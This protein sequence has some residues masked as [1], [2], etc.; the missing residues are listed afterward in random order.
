M[1]FILA[2]AP[3]KGLCERAST[4]VTSGSA[5]RPLEGPTLHG[6][7]ALGR[8]PTASRDNTS[9]ASSLS[10]SPSAHI[11][12]RPEPWRSPTFMSTAR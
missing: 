10:D 2:L 11:L 5:L 3:S 12:G 8:N 7:F 1:L 6:P 9:S 4:S